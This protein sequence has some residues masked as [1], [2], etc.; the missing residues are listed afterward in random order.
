M[1][2]PVT[3]DEAVQITGL[4]IKNGYAA[5]LIQA[6]DGFNLYNMKELRYFTDLVATANDSP[7][8][9]EDVWE[10]ANRKLR[11]TFEGSN[12]LEGCLILRS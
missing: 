8:I 9:S 1:I 3:N 2:D 6:N 11:Q 5:K 7:I 10:E 12:K 4:L